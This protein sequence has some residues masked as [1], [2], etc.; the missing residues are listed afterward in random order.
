MKHR[1]VIILGSGPAGCSAAIYAARSML[2]PLMIHGSEPGGQLTI[3]TDVENYPG[4]TEAIQGPALMQ[5]MEGQALRNGAD[6]AH[7]TITEVD[8]DRKP[9]C[10]K[11]S[12]GDIYTCDSLIIATGASAKWLGLKSELEYR[13]FGVSACATCDGFFF[14][15]KKVCVVGG[16]N[17]AVE[18]A[19]YLAHM[20][21]KVY[22]IHR[23][24]E[25][26][27]EKI[28]QQRVLSNPKIEVIWNS[29]L[30]E[31]IGDKENK[32]VKQALIQNTQNNEAKYINVEGVFIAIGHQPNSTLFKGILD[33]DEENY[34]ITPPGKVTT[35]IK[36]VF[37]VGDVQ[38]KIY[39]QA[40]TAAGTGCMAA[41]DCE[42]YLT[43]E[44]LL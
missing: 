29:Q 42:R 24:D 20:C 38:D 22:L 28:L 2:N 33:M 27:A 37:A 39:R 17:T 40:V 11:G 14:R 3:T 19:L 36:G 8:F 9:F 12:Q 25:L 13:G 16:G 1:K 5:A 32:I 44:G 35:N 15:N 41:L 34:I 7:D 10:L 30:Q 31:I 6:I 23:R 4:F 26:R 18:E 21:S 43:L